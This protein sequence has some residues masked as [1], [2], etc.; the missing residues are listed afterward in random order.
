MN[1][2]K[3][4]FQAGLREIEE[5]PDMLLYGKDPDA[6]AFLARLYKFTPG[7]P[8]G[9]S[10]ASKNGKRHLASRHLD[11]EPPAKRVHTEKPVSAPRAINSSSSKKSYSK[12]GKAPPSVSHRKPKPQQA[13]TP[14]TTAE[15]INETPAPSQ[16]VSSLRLRIRKGKDGLKVSS[17]PT[18]T[19]SDLSPVLGS[20][21]EV[22]T[23]SI[24]DPL[25]I[26]IKQLHSTC[27]T[28]GNH[29]GSRAA[30]VF[31][32]T[33]T[34]VIQAPPTTLTGVCV[35]YPPSSCKKCTAVVTP[36]RRDEAPP[37]PKDELVS[38]SASSDDYE[39][40]RS[41]DLERIG[42]H[43]LKQLESHVLRR[44]HRQCT[45]GKGK[46]VEKP[47][48]SLSDDIACQKAICTPSDA[49]KA[50]EF[51]RNSPK[52]TSP[53]LP[54]AGHIPAD[55]PSPTIPPA[56]PSDVCITE[57][58]QQQEQQLRDLDTEARLLL[59][60]RSIKSSLVQDHEDIATC[61]DRLEMLD[62]ISTT[63][64]VLAKCWTVVQTIGK[65]RRY[66][67][68]MEVKIAAQRVFNNFLQL[69][70]TSDKT[71][72]DL[73]LAE[74]MR[75]QQRHIK[76]HAHVK[77]DIPP[78]TGPKSMSE[79]FQVSAGVLA[80]RRSVGLGTAH[81]PGIQSPLSTSPVVSE[82]LPKS[83]DVSTFP[84]HQT[85]YQTILDRVVSSERTISG[86][87]LPSSLSV[88]DIP[89]PAE[90][91][92]GVSKSLIIHAPPTALPANVNTEEEYEV[93]DEYEATS[94][95]KLGFEQL[96]MLP[97]SSTAT[98]TSIERAPTSMVETQII[99]YDMVPPHML[100]GPDGS[101]PPAFRSSNASFPPNS[102]VVPSC[103]HMCSLPSVYSSS[104]L[105]S[106]VRRPQSYAATPNSLNTDAPFPQIASSVYIPHGLHNDPT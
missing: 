87:S 36:L 15:E 18:P 80:E 41:T 54:H 48:A 92:A 8:S 59:I 66:K 76:Q 51:A 91:P 86:L 49:T 42:T 28:V 33:T 56:V 79:L 50:E 4:A 94:E 105:S 11:N 30:P 106:S 104:C 83:V 103:S 68:S 10:V 52:P 61:V 24:N 29:A 63:L 47:K 5:N 77:T 96:D 60:D 99:P 31:S 82:K 25:R 65:C 3:P 100:P 101:L 78:Y 23:L 55:L 74:L 72:L 70:A 81:Q 95:N 37:C 71:E 69:Y 45:T 34:T 85:S 7:L 53:V 2:N 20:F 9:T 93:L 64:P 75:H 19:P 26:T 1:R 57:P 46:E 58:K 43:P 39:E 12:P 73:A 97:P 44:D 84:A 27:T 14:A 90:V 35:K 89:L 16:R 6:E 38:L 67:R 21:A 40:T 102:T 32:V 88:R 98:A 17:A 62:R 13:P 22:S